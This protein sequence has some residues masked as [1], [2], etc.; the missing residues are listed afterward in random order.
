MNI[1]LKHLLDFKS[2][3]GIFAWKED[4]VVYTKFYHVKSLNEV[5]ITGM[6]HK[7]IKETVDLFFKE[8]PYLIRK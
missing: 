2:I 8:N 5:N 4:K 1:V 7:E 3:I 6:W